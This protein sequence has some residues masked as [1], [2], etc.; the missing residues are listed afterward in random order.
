MASKTWFRFVQPA[1]NCSGFC[2]RKRAQ[3]PHA[4]ERKRFSWDSIGTGPA[5]ALP[6][7]YR[8]GI[9]VGGD[10]GSGLVHKFQKK[11]SQSRPCLNYWVQTV[12]KASWSSLADVTAT[13][14]SANYVPPFVVFDLCGN[15]YRMAALVD[16]KSGIVQIDEIMTHPEYDRWSKKRR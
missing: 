6:Y 1:Y 4:A 9:C 3:R 14:N 16:F 2:V 10:F 15:K 8:F 11:H 7:L 5:Y 13:F 12:E